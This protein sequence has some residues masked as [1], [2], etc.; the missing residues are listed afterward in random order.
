[1]VATLEPTDDGTNLALEM[2]YTVPFG[3]VGRWIDRRWIDREPRTIENREFDRLVALVT[4]PS[5]VPRP[6]GASA[7]VESATR[8]VST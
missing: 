8:K 6:H 5:L 4:D 7:P 2:E 1:M 3:D